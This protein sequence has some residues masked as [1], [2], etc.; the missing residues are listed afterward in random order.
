[1]G[2]IGR[3]HGVLGE[4]TIEVRTDLPEERFFI[5]SVLQCQGPD[6][7]VTKPALT[8]K[9]VRVHNGTFLLGFDGISNRN[10]IEE[11]RD[12]ILYSDVDIEADSVHED[13]YHVLQLIDCEVFT[14]SN[15]RVG[16]VSDV[17][18]LP[19]HDLLAVAT[20]TREVLIPFV[21]EI[22]PRVDVKAKIITINPPQGLL[23]D[24]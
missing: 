19:G 6:Q 20:G 9:S 21:L 14:T 17:I 2:R 16:V 3:A 13:D 24:I 22:V 10:Q 1:M 4:A 8:V 11:L 7:P 23:D 15:E 12:T 18:A 5:G